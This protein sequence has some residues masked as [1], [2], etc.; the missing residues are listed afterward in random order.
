MW[1]RSDIVCGGVPLTHESRSPARSVAAL[2]LRL[3]LAGVFLRAGWAKVSS[4]P[5]IIGLWQQRLHLPLPHVFG[6]IH[7]IVEFGGGIL[8]LVGLLTRLVSFLLA[9]DMFGALI[10]VKIHTPTFFSQEW[11]AFWISLALFATGAGAY[12]LDALFRHRRVR[13]A[14]HSS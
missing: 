9:V 2:C 12:S 11:L 4:L 3:G 10:L 6:P 5:G 7:A 13:A 14:P 8:A 1:R